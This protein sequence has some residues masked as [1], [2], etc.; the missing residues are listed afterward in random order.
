M[1]L[2]TKNAWLL[3]GHIARLQLSRL[4][5]IVD[6]LRPAAGLRIQFADESRSDRW[7]LLGVGLPDRR[8]AADMASVDC[9]VRGDDLVA[10]FEETAEHP[11]RA[12]IYWRMLQREMP[13]AGDI[14]PI[15]GIELIVSV[16]THLLDKDP[17]LS[18]SSRLPRG[19]VRRL[20]DVESGRFDA[21]E[22]VQG[23]TQS[24]TPLS[25]Y[26]CL[27]ARLPE[28]S[29]L[30]AEMVH[31][32]DFQ[33]TD[34]ELTNS[35]RQAISWTHCLFPQHLEKGVILRSR[36]CGFFFRADASDAVVA[37][38]YREFAASP[39]PLTV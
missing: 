2:G 23:G 14:S 18:V 12:Q 28:S 9:F 8:A 25:G 32:A 10:T 19:S 36:I 26:G 6:V 11:L 4:T 22:P 20:A 24:F 5:A 21:V 29:L 39:P 1:S 31:P 34:V 37:A 15:A 13:A 7:G 30:Y 3:E 27:I 38:A 17:A 35:D 33:R 16:Q